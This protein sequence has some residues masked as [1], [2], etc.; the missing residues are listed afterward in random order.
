[1]RKSIFAILAATF[2]FSCSDHDHNSIEPAPSHPDLVSPELYGA[3]N[4]TTKSPFTGILDVYPCNEGNSIYF[5]NYFN[6][7]ITPMNAVYT[8]SNGSSS[9]TLRPVLLPIGNYNIVYWGMPKETETIYTGMAINDPPLRLNTDLS[10][11]YFSLRKHEV[12]SDTTYYP[13]FNYVFAVVPTNIGTDKLSASLQRVVAG[14]NITI[15]GK[16]GGEFDTNVESVQVLIGNIA[17]KLDVF[18]ATP[19][20]QTKTVQFPLELSD[21]GKQMSVPTVMLFPSAPNPPIQIIITLKN[22]AIKTYKQSLT[23]TLNANTKLS[24]S[25]TLNEI[26]SSEST[27]GDFNVSNWN[28]KN[29]SID[30]PPI[31]E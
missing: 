31:G 20:N 24:L 29:E 5:G 2:L 8:V 13:V 10:Q 3:T 12:A 4:A 15:T 11:T 21:D 16:D 9:T 7:T 6:S 17:E 25:M 28:E 19:V 30:L 18:T 1:M 23:T 14:I 27:T 26:F 22:G